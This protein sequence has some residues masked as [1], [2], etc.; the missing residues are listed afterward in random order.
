MNFKILLGAA[1]IFL[2]VVSFNANAVTVDYSTVYSG[3]DYLALDPITIRTPRLIQISD[4]FDSAAITLDF[5]VSFDY[6]YGIDTDISLFFGL[7]N[8]IYG[9]TSTY[10]YND[11]LTVL[12][13]SPSNTFDYS[14]S[15][16]IDG[17]DLNTLYSTLIVSA[18][19]NPL[20]LP[21]LSLEYVGWSSS[22]TINSTP[23]V[24]LGELQRH[25]TYLYN[26]SVV[27]VP[28]A[29][30]LFCSGLIG[31]VGMARGKKS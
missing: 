18:V 26:A 30:W 1:S 27:P 28:A 25:S 6:P 5:V 8:V 2:S 7:T 17:L 4:G 24:D 31:L 15:I 3:G 19:S 11:S 9:T 29:V 21:S 12:G 10:Y 13:V 14:G 23:E 22:M 16:T 20:N